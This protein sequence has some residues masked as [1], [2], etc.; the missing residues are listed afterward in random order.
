M[1]EIRGGGGGWQGMVVG[2]GRAAGLE[3]EVERRRNLAK[4]PAGDRERLH[5]EIRQNSY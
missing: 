1:R 5:N 3:V 4:S 2:K